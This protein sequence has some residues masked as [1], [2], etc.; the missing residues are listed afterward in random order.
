MPAAPLEATTIPYRCSG[1]DSTSRA[2]PDDEGSDTVVSLVE[3]SVALAPTE[4]PENSLIL[5]PGQTS[6]VTVT[7]RVP[8]LVE[9]VALDR[10]LAWREG[11]F[12]FNDM[13]LKAIISEIE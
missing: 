6:H 10:V 5:E 9:T 4:W 11:G 13:S 12:F 8:S 7:S 3:G 1:H 2:W